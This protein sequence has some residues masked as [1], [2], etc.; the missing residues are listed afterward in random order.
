[1]PWTPRSPAHRDP[2][3]WRR[4]GLLPPAELDALVRARLGW[5]AVEDPAYADFFTD[6]TA[7]LPGE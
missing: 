3:Q 5:L 6:P 1:M 2:E 4:R 7:A